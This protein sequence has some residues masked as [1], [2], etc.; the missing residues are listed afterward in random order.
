[1]QDWPAIME[2]KGAVVVEGCLLFSPRFF[3]QTSGELKVAGARY[4]VDP[5]KDLISMGFVGSPSW[6]YQHSW[7]SYMRYGVDQLMS[8]PSHTYSYKVVER[9]GD[10][11][12]FRIMRVGSGAKPVGEQ[13]YRLPDVEVVEVKG[14]E[15]MSYSKAARSLRPRTYRFPKPLWYDMLNH[16]ALEFE[17]GKLDFAALVNYYRTVAPRQTINATLVMGGFTVDLVDLVP[18][19][20]HAGLAAAH[21]VFLNQKTVRGLTDMAMQERELAIESTLYKLFDGLWGTIQ[22]VVSIPLVPFKLLG[23][24]LRMAHRAVVSTKVLTW[25]PVVSVVRVSAVHLL[26]SHVSRAH[27]RAMGEV[28]EHA[29]AGHVAEDAPFDQL[30]VA[31]REPEIANM[32][33]DLCKSWM[34]KSHVR[35]LEAVANKSMASVQPTPPPTY[36]TGSVVTDADIVQDDKLHVERVLA[37]QE[38]IEEAEMDNRKL[39]E[40]CSRAYTALTRSG[41]PVG[42]LIKKF[43]ELYCN[44]DFWQVKNGVLQG[45]LLGLQASD[46][47]HSAV[48]SARADPTTGSQVMAVFEDTWS[49]L[50]ADGVFVT[51]EYKLISDRTYSGWVMTSDLL[52]IFNGPEILRAMR[53]ALDVR[54]DYRVI[55][56]EGPPGCGKTTAIVEAVGPDDCVMCPVRESI[57]DTRARVMEKLSNFIGPRTRLRTVDSYLTNYYLDAKTESMRSEVLLADES[58]MTHSGKWYSCAGLLGVAVVYAYGDTQQI[59]HIPRVQAAKLYVRIAAQEVRRKWLTYRC[60]ADAVVAWNHLYGNCVRTVSKVRD[61]M[62]V[63]TS[64]RGLD[65]PHGCVMMCMYQADKKILRDVYAQSIK[66]KN[67]KIVTAHEAE[68]KTYKD[69]WLHRFDVRKRTDDFSLFDQSQHVLVAMSRHTESFVYV[70]PQD[71]GDLVST[72]ISQV[73]PRKVQAVLDVTSAGESY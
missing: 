36:R 20:V 39:V 67:L 26:G 68:G 72:W 10:T 33:L 46:F 42:S 51:R 41:K 56:E 64:S 35:A 15:L 12:F 57:Q 61:S 22:A 29:Y 6:W 60:P 1:M 70:C 13:Y 55:L 21:S 30:L 28:M 19:V 50:D 47:R 4:E 8:T 54:H 58:F 69:V 9:R 25:N 43:E 2:K 62:R 38:A 5:A 71:V 24:L 34:P 16:A 52:V 49:G 65:I 31:I 37:I 27:F 48:Y 23:S 3:E 17:R 66:P 73:S 40:S 59:P 11:L 45:S 53:A 18:L 7:S 32:M 44:P 14:F 63:V